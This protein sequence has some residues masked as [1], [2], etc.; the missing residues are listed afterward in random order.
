MPIPSLV[1]MI[2]R[3]QT[4]AGKSTPNVPLIVYSPAEDRVTSIQAKQSFEG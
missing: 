2:T 3:W 1:G 4:C